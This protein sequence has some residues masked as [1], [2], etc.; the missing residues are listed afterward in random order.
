[1]WLIWFANEPLRPHQARV[2]TDPHL[3]QARCDVP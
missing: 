3:S 1:S 2:A